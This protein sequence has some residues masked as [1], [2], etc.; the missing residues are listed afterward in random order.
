MAEVRIVLKRSP[1]DKENGVWIDDVKVED[2]T[3]VTV[4]GSANQ[5]PQVVITLLPKKLT[6]GLDN[7]DIDKVPNDSK[8]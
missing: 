4:F 8:N 2:V 1:M 3:E 6:L 7:P 5:I